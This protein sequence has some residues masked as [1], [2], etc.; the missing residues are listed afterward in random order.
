VKK[1][2]LAILLS[3]AMVFS[4]FPVSAFASGTTSD[5]SDMPSN[6]STKALENAVSNGLLSGYNGKIMP[7]DNLTR[8]QM[9]AVVNRA[10]GTTEKASLSSYTDVAA[11]AWYYDDMAKAVQMKT[12]VGSGDK[13]NPAANITREEAFAVLTRAF[14][15]SG[16]DQ[17]ALDKFSDKTLVSSWAKDGMASLV[18]TGYVV[19]SDGQLNPKQN[20]TRAEFA[21]IRDNI[22]KNYIKTAGTYTTDYTGNVMI[23]VPGVTLKD[24]KITG[25]LIIGD[26]VGN[27]DVTLDGVTV[28]GRLL[29]QTAVTLIGNTVVDPSVELGAAVAG[30]PIASDVFTGATVTRSADGTQLAFSWTNSGSLGQISVL[31]STE[32][33]SVASGK[34]VASVE[35]A[36]TATSGSVTITD[37]CPNSRP[38]F[39]LV[40]TAGAKIS[41]AERGLQIAGVVNARDLGGYKTT[42]GKYVKWGVL[43][44][45]AELANVT[46][47]GAAYI[48]NLGVKTII[49]LRTPV[50]INKSPEV[51]FAGITAMH[52]NVM[53]DDF[54]TKFKDQYPNFNWAALQS[55]DPSPSLMRDYLRM[56]YRCYIDYAAPQ[57][58]ANDF[59]AFLQTNTSPVIWHCSEGKDRTGLKAA[60]L[61]YALGV[62]EDTI[63]KDF[64]LTN[65]FVAAA[66][67]DG[68]KRF[69]A[70]AFYAYYGVDSSYLATAFN[71]M[72][73]KYGSIDNYLTQVCGLTA[74]K[75]ADLK[76]H[77]LQN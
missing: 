22:L 35:G 65:D 11:N 13:L 4:L 59:M 44:R 73:S 52:I 74:A 72:K 58:E 77:Y 37:P 32:A 71:E 49:D 64:M 34:V 3:L 26:G 55:T 15:L 23:N 43:F 53:G 7:N 68:L 38:Y 45:T 14:K 67:P 18:T 47:S 25:D 42:D 61:L 12:F 2:A 29:A 33:D 48:K 20:I 19:G 6:W 10:F 46:T 62:P 70:D 17:S 39:Q 36:I 76:A 30:H 16:A 24:I 8:A 1:K 31:F 57:Q 75:R 28:K 56:F 5:F 54:N 51:T 69:G 50:D 27:G 63:L 60:T 41:V 9:A 21:Q 40:S 66:N